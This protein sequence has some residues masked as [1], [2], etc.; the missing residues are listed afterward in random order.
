M[1]K[2]LFM[3]QEISFFGLV[4][5]KKGVTMDQTKVDAL[6]SALHLITEQCVRAKNFVVFYTK[7]FNTYWPT[8]T[9]AKK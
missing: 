3:T 1:K 9:T 8:T 6:K 7:L 5:G 2:C 4:I